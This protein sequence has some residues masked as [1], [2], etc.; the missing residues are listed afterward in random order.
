M[1]EGAECSLYKA[2]FSQNPYFCKQLFSLLLLSLC[3]QQAVVKWYH[4]VFLPY[5]IIV[6]SS[7]HNI[8]HIMMQTGAQLG[9]LEGHFTSL[10]LSYYPL[11]FFLF[12]LLD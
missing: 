8:N 10:A 11:S 5:I 4:R 9:S 6:L 2:L 1:T 7:H 12:S 3:F